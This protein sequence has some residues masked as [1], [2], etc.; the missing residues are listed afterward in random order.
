MWHGTHLRRKA[1]VCQQVPTFLMCQE[2]ILHQRLSILNFSIQPLNESLF[3]FS[4][5]VEWALTDEL[6]CLRTRGRAVLAAP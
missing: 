2:F 1:E 3:C 6:M 4:Y 5:E